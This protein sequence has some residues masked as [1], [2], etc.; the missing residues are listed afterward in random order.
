MLLRTLLVAGAGL[1]AACGSGDVASTLPPTPSTLPEASSSPSAP[2][3]VDRLSADY[4]PGLAAEVRFPVAAGAAPLIVMVP[5]GGWSSADPT[6]LVPLADRLTAGGAS[7]ALITYSTTGTGSTFPEAVDDVACAV[8]W[9]A[10]EA[11][12]RGHPP[13]SVVLLGHSAGGHLSALVA[14]SGDEFGAACPDP[15]VDVDGLIG[16]AG[17]YDTDQLRPY[18]TDWMGVGATDA[19]DLWRRANPLEWVREGS[20]VPDDLRVLLVHGDADVTVP[21]SQTTALAD[22]LTDAGIQARTTVLP[23]LDH[24]EV[25]Q[26]EHAGPPIE[27]WLAAAAERARGSGARRAATSALD[28]RELMIGIARSVFVSYFAKRGC[29]A[30]IIRQAAS[31]SSPCSCSAVTAV[32]APSTTMRT[33]SGWAARL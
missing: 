32:S 5:G 14:F 8:R 17:V 27:A 10:R 25:F 16:L 33:R 23:G 9:A 28:G 6:G 2:T 4:L 11:A 31:R 30:V 19:P 3:T 26:A 29:A 13:T 24:L 21:L 7:T 12:T 1:L 15:Y 18:L 22:A 20:R